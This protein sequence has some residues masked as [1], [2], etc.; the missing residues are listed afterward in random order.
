VHQTSAITSVLLILALHL[1]AL[2][3]S[4]PVTQIDR[5]EQLSSEYL[6]AWQDGRTSSYRSL[7]V[8]AD[9]AQAKLNKDP[10]I[11]LMYLDE[12][13]KPV[14]YRI[15]NLI[16]AQTISTDEVWPGGSGGLNLDGSSTTLGELGIWDAGAVRTTHREFGGRVTQIDGATST[17]FHAT[18]VAGTLVASGFIS[19]AK[20]M[21]FAAPLASFDWSFD[22]SEM[23]SAAAAGMNVSNHSY[24]LIA[25]WDFS[26]GSWYW[27]GDIDVSRAEDWRFG[28]Y[29]SYAQEWDDI[30]YNAPYYTI[31]IS[32]ANER[33]D[34]GPGPG[35]G[36][37]HW[38]NG[39]WVWSTDAHNPD[40]GTNG[41]DCLGFRA[42][43][44]NVLAVGAVDD[45]PGGYTTPG[46]VAMSAFSSWGPTDDGRIKPDL[47]ANGI[48]LYSCLD[49]S[50][51]QYGSLS[52]TS[53]ASPS[54]A[55][56][57]NLLVRLYES[58]HGEL[59]PLSSTMKAVLIQSADEAGDYPGPDA[60]FGWGLMNTLKAAQLITSDATV[61]RIIEAQ[62]SNQVVDTCWLT[63]DG[64]TPICLTLAWIDPPGVPPEPSLDPTTSA[65]VN[66]LDLTVT[67]I[68]SGTKYYPFV[69]DPSQPG[70]PPQTPSAGNNVDNVEQV[71]LTSSLSGVY[72]V[73]VAHKGN[74]ASDQYY[75]LASSHA[76]RFNDLDADGVKDQDDNCPTVYN[77]AQENSDRD[78]IGDSCD[79]C[80]YIY[81]PN[82]ADSNLNDIGDVCDGIHLWHVATSGDD[83][84]GHG[85]SAMPFATIQHAVD[86]AS[87][88]DTVFIHA[89]VYYE[90][91]V[92]P[93][94]IHLFAE[95]DSGTAMLDVRLM[96]HQTGHDAV[97]IE[98][99]GC[100]GEIANLDIYNRANRGISLLTAGQ[101]NWRVHHN[102]IVTELAD[103]IAT[104]DTGVIERN[105]IRDGENGVSVTQGGRA[106]IYNNVITGGNIGILGLESAHSVDIQGNVIAAT[107]CAIQCLLTN[108]R[109][110]YNDFWANGSV[111][112][113]LANEG[114]HDIFE[115]PL[116]VADSLYDYRLRP[117][118]PCINAG[119]PSLPLD[120]DNTVADIGVYF[121]DHRGWTCYDSD[122][123]YYGDPGHPENTCMLD[124]CTYEQNPNQ[125]DLDNDGVG[126][127]CDNCT[128]IANA[129]QTDAD[130]DG[131]GDACDNCPNTNNP[132][133]LD[134]DKDGVGDA[135]DPDI[136]NDGIA[137]Q[138]DNCIYIANFSQL[139]SDADSLGDACDNCPLV[140]N[141]DQ[142][143]SDSNGVGDWC[144]GKVHIQTG[145]I[146]PEAFLNQCY[147]LELQYA[148]GVSPW[149]W[150]F[151]GG[152]LP[153]GLNFTGGTVGTISGKPIYKNNYFFTVAL[154]DG[155]NPA[156]VDTATLSLRVTDQVSVTYVCGDANG[157][158]GVDISDVVFLIARIFSGGQAPNPPAAGDANCDNSVDI[159]DVV[160]LVAN[161]FSGGAPPC[162]AC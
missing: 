41:F 77:P 81:N 140:Y 33:N 124:N 5:L 82:Q 105:V 138:D 62:L 141:P 109:I 53:M 153:D 44:K 161:I 126:D 3:G 106:K 145:P 130:G 104:Q 58:I 51:S 75:S 66:N 71:K 17:H 111:Y 69:L 9:S 50:D 158:C 85:S 91:V 116:F 61:E 135:C 21:S 102:T 133:Q 16:A 101:G 15:N 14:Y 25:G 11:E 1:P 38:E 22:E 29:T 37:Y 98:C 28:F 68:A 35:E 86:I 4:R 144:D 89:G 139:D 115:E 110:D 72:L 23:A 2:A 136:D 54:V 99:T 119:N 12:R 13:R 100:S 7:L 114:A 20:G 10:N 95:D 129:T 134:T 90:N 159:S 18:H 32:A 39:Q 146:L 79:N 96:A 63:G 92:C 131:I 70:G 19:P 47:V 94:S 127:I 52:G 27:H 30:A 24:G 93:K 157:D 43:A 122:G 45:I 152:D 31:V 74:L 155:S 46:S 84:T 107:N 55:G 108:N 88:G 156:K 49:G 154:R 117:G 42:C 64:S 76:L 60:K 57:L 65:L 80:L 113:A 6:R 40:G 143:D 26:G 78:E 120:P 97:R 148:G 112:C 151:V 121:F 73:T 67:H 56:A 103:G 128:L 160:Y 125:A 147:K 83:D 118:S 162:A 150:S 36:H 34:S 149:T 137:N 59:T 142:W 123:D 132:S 87:E 48:G 8:S